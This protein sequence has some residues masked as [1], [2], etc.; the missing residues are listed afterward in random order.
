MP[1]C[2]PS[3]QIRTASNGHTAAFP[4][5]SVDAIALVLDRVRHDAGV[6]TLHSLL[7]C[8]RESAHS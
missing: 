5:G 8:T 2:K 3:K 1:Y 4:P 6:V 7:P